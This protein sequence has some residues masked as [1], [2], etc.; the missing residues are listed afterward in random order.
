[1]PRL[2]AAA[3]GLL[4]LGGC[5]A[6]V[7]MT[8]AENAADPLC[9]E[10]IVRLP[11][12]I[13]D[14]EQRETDA[15]ATSAWGTPAQILMTC[16]VAV[17]APSQLRCADISGVD[18]LIDDTDPDRGVFT[19]YGRDPAVRVVVDTNLSDSG[20]LYALTDAVA[21]NPATRTCT[22]AEDPLGG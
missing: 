4:V 20:V 13:D 12:T 21:A 10:I 11:E 9:A 18:W 7:P 15:Q 3:A 5:A 16:G 14:L 8:P 17:P 6:T 22:A 1:M 2:I 19:T